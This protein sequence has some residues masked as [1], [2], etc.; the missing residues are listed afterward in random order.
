MIP[1]NL[2]NIIFLF[3][4]NVYGRHQLAL[5]DIFLVIKLPFT[6]Q[7]LVKESSL[8]HSVHESQIMLFKD[9][10]FKLQQV[11]FGLLPM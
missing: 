5:V 7:D 8:P 1:F 6:N 4:R 11:F 10:A 3:I 9:K 2:C